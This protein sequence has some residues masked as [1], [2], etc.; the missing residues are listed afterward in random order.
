MEGNELI[1]PDDIIELIIVQ[2]PSLALYNRRCMRIAMSSRLK[3]T[4]PRHEWRIDS[5]DSLRLMIHLGHADSLMMREW[6]ELSMT[7]LSFDDTVHGI[8]L[9]INQGIIPRTYEIF[10]LIQLVDAEIQRRNNT[11]Y[12][13][14][15]E[16]L[17]LVM[18]YIVDDPEELITLLRHRYISETVQQWVE[19][20]TNWYLNRSS[21]PMWTSITQQRLDVDDEYI[22]DSVE[23]W[24]SIDRGNKYNISYCFDVLI[25]AYATNI[26]KDIIR[27]HPDY[28]SALLYTCVDN[29]VDCDGM[30]AAY[31]WEA[32]NISWWLITE[33]P[34]TFDEYDSHDV[35]RVLNNLPTV[36]ASRLRNLLP[37]DMRYINTDDFI[38]WSVPT[39][40][41]K[42]N[43]R[44]RLTRLIADPTI[45][46]GTPIHQ[47]I[48]ELLQLS[49]HAYTDKSIQRIG[50]LSIL[51]L[52]EEWSH[53][54]LPVASHGFWIRVRVIHDNLPLLQRLHQLAGKPRIP[55][56][57]QMHVYHIYKRSP[58]CLTWL[59]RSKLLEITPPKVYPQQSQ[60]NTFI[61]W[62]TLIPR[63]TTEYL[64]LQIDRQ[65]PMIASII[66]TELSSRD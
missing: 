51:Q 6:V 38:R 2:Y 47:R 55:E 39:V 23:I 21:R 4:L 49:P 61:V 32:L 14:L 66:G 17:C 35:A 30:P 29:I 8:Q 20:M 41:I 36:H 40:S 10:L 18:C 56:R 65:P 33:C 50:R 43:L 7:H 59:F 45:V 12:D 11:S 25:K 52:L 63:L 58:M 53:G 46:S 13:I 27:Q 9:I 1:L 64:R 34:L 62:S 57:Q 54:E 22:T 60:R 44:K 16:L 15:H 37:V 48:K 28:A 5:L 31:A 24:R 26:L 42:H 19:E 3:T